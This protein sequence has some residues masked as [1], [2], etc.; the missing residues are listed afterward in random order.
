MN[1][2]LTGPAGDKFSHDE[3]FSLK[4]DPW[5]Q[6]AKQVREMLVMCSPQYQYVKERLWYT[7]TYHLQNKIYKENIHGTYT[8][9][10]KSYEHGKTKGKKSKQN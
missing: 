10:L 6:S 9:K 2:Y 3:L 1:R 7:I 4:S 8:R 5:S